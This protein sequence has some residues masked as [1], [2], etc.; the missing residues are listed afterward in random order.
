MSKEPSTLSRR[1]FTA[2]TLAA[3][4]DA[5]APSAA[6][7]ANDVIDTDVRIETAN[8]TCDAALILPRSKGPSPAV[9]LFPDAFG[10]RPAMRT[11]ARRLALSGYAVLVPNPYYRSTTAPGLSPG[12]DFANPL[13]RA[14]LDALRAPLTG[15]AVMRDSRAYVGF[16]D[17]RP[18]I[19][20]KAKM[21]VV[22]YCMG[23]AMTMQAAA[24]NPDR[25]GAGASFHGGGLV[26][27]NPGSPHLLVPKIKARYYFGVADNDDRQQP[28]AKGALAAAFAATGVPAKIEVYAGTQHGWCVPDMPMKDGKPIYDER[29]AERAWHE[30]IA[31]Y[32]MARV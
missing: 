16:L 9:I 13:D 17:A 15:D 2:L 31:L 14:K 7:D 3:G 8:G 32:R 6:A 21:G 26:T 27:G 4:I 24:A 30:L 1:R 12:F 25:I 11:M 19:D 10:L 20:R 22:G 23:G 29:E 5:A 18:D 28:E